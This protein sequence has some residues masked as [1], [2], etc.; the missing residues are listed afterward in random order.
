MKKYT[1]KPIK[2]PSVVK[3]RK[4]NAKMLEAY[5]YYFSLG[6]GRTY[7]QV[8]EKYKV[9][10]QTVYIW[11]NRFKWDER[12]AERDQLIAKRLQRQTNNN[13]VKSKSQYRED[14]ASHLSIINEAILTAIDK[15]TKEVILKIKTPNDLNLLITA[16]ER[17]VKLDLDLVKSGSDDAVDSPINKL[18][19]ILS[20]ITNGTNG[21]NEPTEVNNG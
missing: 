18:V 15:T 3:K 2:K 4:E 19:N 7:Q 11:K 21:A 16:Y 12:I 5:D 9:H 13:I 1:R 10:H 6:P 20:N 14:I 8:A 17:L